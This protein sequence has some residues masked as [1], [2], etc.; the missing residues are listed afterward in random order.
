MDNELRTLNFVKIARNYMATSKISDLIY[1]AYANL[2]MADYAVGKGLANY[3]RTCFMIRTRLYKGLQCG[4]MKIHSLFDDEKVKLGNGIKCVYCGA[5]SDIS[6]DHMIPRIKGGTDVSDNLVCAC[7]TCNSSKGKRDLMEWY[8]EKQSFPP[9]MVLRRY[10]K[11]VYNYCYSN[12]LLDLKLEDQKLGN[13]PFSIK[14]LPIHYPTPN[15][16]QY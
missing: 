11:L 8:N 1:Y 9:L 4:N 10:I 3:D 14:S 15:K 12:D 16:L 2:A 6:I 7:K 13:L 5:E